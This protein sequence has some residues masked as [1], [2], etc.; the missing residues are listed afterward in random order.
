M[1]GT[2]FDKHSSWFSWADEILGGILAL[3]QE[4]LGF[5]PI[6]CVETYFVELSREKVQDYAS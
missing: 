2:K 4:Y 3:H 5:K 6:L 1:G